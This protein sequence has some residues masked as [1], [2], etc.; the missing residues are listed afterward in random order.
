MDW[1]T[2]QAIDRKN[3]L[4][5]NDLEILLSLCRSP[6]DEV[7]RYAA[8]LL[9]MASGEQAEQTLIGVCGDEE[10]VVRANACDSLRDYRRDRQSPHA[11]IKGYDKPNIERYVEKRG[12]NQEK[13]R[14]FGIPKRLK[15]G[16]T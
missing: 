8:E 15:N 6:D 1:E 7:R 16:I 12:K 2:L 14:Y 5:E 9:V 13:Q 3:R 10:E 4:D 11:H